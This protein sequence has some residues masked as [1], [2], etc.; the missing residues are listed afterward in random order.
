MGCLILA[1]VLVDENVAMSSRQ[2]KPLRIDP[3]RL[4]PVREFLA[5]PIGP[6][7][8]ELDAILSVLRAGP[9]AGKYCLICV[10]PHRRW[11][12]GRLSGVRGEAPRVAD[13][14][15]FHNLEDAERAVFR[16]RWTAETG[17]ALDEGLFE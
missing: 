15:V 17:V 6:H 1:A 11:V 16:L 8:A 4:E 12:I 7:G 10:E 9:V 13:N 2:P 14:R 3:T 5:T